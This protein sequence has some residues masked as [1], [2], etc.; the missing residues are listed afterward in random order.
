MD[1]EKDIW[2]ELESG[3]SSSPTSS[4][5]ESTETLPQTTTNFNNQTKVFLEQIKDKHKKDD[6]EKIYETFKNDNELVMN[7][8]KFKDTIAVRKNGKKLKRSL[9]FC[10]LTG[11]Y[12]VLLSLFYV[13][14]AVCLLI[15]EF[16]FTF[17][18]IKTGKKD[19]PKIDA[20]NLSS[21]ITLDR[22]QDPLLRSLGTVL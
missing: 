3:H 1:E 19:R 5:M 8:K 22:K 4:T 10:T 14:S 2:D 13:K 9:T 6:L 21:L 16:L 11:I 15:A 17:F 18:Y 7:P 12:L 20:T